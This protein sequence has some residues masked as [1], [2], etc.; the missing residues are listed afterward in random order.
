MKL[1]RGAVTMESPEE[2]EKG[3]GCPEMKDIRLPVDYLSKIQDAL[4]PLDLV[5]C[6][7]EETLYSERKSGFILRMVPVD[8]YL[9]SYPA[10]P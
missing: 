1:L 8:G 9:C 7:Y 6:G 4:F 2:N 3:S 10:K 5:V